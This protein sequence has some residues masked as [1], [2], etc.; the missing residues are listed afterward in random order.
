MVICF[1]VLVYHHGY[2]SYART[3][4]ISLGF[5]PGHMIF[6]YGLIYFLIPRF[7]FKRELGGAIAGFILVLFAALLYGKIADVYILQY[8]GRTG[9]LDHVFSSIPRTMLAIFATAGPAVSIKLVRTWYQEKEAQSRL[10]KEKLSAEL[11]TLKAQMQPHFLFN[12][13][14]NIYALS[15]EQ[16]TQTPMALLKLSGLLRYVLYECNGAEAPLSREIQCIRDYI[17]LEQ[18]RYGQTL[19]VGFRCKGELD[20]KRIAPLLLLPLIE[21]SF[22]HGTSEQI[23]QCWIMFDLEVEGAVLKLKLTNSR[24]VHEGDGGGGIG[25]QQVRRRLAL[26]YPGQHALKIIPD[27]DTFTVSLILTLRLQ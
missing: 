26:T 24:N 17:E 13:L 10:E 6:I 21:N 22:K 5:L 11:E 3:I 16:S 9:L 18:L 12:T 23:D 4:V 25:L 2:E 20:G 27:E 8:S 14:N 15:I 1:N 19:D 7:I